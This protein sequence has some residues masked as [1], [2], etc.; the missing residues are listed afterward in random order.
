MLVSFDQ[1]VR[2]QEK[3][4]GGGFRRETEEKEDFQETGG[5]TEARPGPVEVG[6]LEVGLEVCR[7]TLHGGAMVKAGSGQS[8]K[9]VGILI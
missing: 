1:D 7:A 8:S 2:G 9:E 5:C 4:E 3:G 6:E